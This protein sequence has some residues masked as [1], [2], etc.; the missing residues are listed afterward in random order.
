MK[1][2][3]PEITLIAEAVVLVQ[4]IKLMGTADFL[5]PQNPIRSASAYESDE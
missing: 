4:G 1:Y 5:E 3:K 2:E